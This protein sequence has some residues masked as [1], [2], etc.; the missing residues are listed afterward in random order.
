MSWQNIMGSIIRWRKGH[1]SNRQ[2]RRGQT[3]NDL[4]VNEQMLSSQ[5]HNCL[6][7]RSSLSFS[8][9]LWIVFVMKKPPFLSHSCKTCSSLGSCMSGELNAAICVG[10]LCFSSVTRVLTSCCRTQNLHH[11][12]VDEPML[13]WP[14]ITSIRLKPEGWRI[15]VWRE[16]TQRNGGGGVVSI[17]LRPHLGPKLSA[18]AKVPTMHA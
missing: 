6:G 13:T 7:T 15:P 9:L 18:T 16:G 3:M 8:V 10:V 5:G 12:T 4:K 14:S 11:I 1:H 17:Q 2:A